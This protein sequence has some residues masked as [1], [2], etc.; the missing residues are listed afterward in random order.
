ML[1]LTL[2][3]GNAAE[4]IL[5]PLHICFPPLAPFFAVSYTQVQTLQIAGVIFR[6]GC[7]AGWLQARVGVFTYAEVCGVRCSQREVGAGF[8]GAG[9]SGSAR[10]TAREANGRSCVHRNSKEIVGGERRL[11][12]QVGLLC[13]QRTQ[14]VATAAPR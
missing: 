3:H 11:A 8:S 14:E 12:G 6:P 4:H 7:I 1:T 9:F 10:P 13:L 5:P 2:Q